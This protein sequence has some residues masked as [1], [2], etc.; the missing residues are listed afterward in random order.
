MTLSE[1]VTLGAAFESVVLSRGAATTL[2]Q[3]MAFQ[4][5]HDTEAGMALRDAGIAFGTNEAEP[6][7]AE[8]EA[9]DDPTTLKPRSSRATQSEQASADT[10]STAGDKGRGAS[11]NTASEISSKPSST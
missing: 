5:G 6:V 10:P 11:S 1:D 2:L 9:L 4:V 8:D 3:W 7:E